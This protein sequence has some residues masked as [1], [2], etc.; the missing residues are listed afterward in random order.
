MRRQQNFLYLSLS[1]NVRSVYKLFKIDNICSIVEKFYPQNFPEWE[2]QL[3]FQVQ[4][5]EYNV[6]HHSD[7]QN[8][9]TTSDLY[10]ALVKT[11]KSTVIIQ[12]NAYCDTSRSY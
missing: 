2:I 7:L 4:H 5:Y 3:K 6:P 1:L 11:C 8:F 9:F 10:Q 12:N